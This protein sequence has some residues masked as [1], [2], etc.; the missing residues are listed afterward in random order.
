MLDTGPQS[1]VHIQGVAEWSLVW[2]IFQ[3]FDKNR[4]ERSDREAKLTIRKWMS[5]ESTRLRLGEF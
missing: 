4:F 3:L 1:I 5:G 2:E